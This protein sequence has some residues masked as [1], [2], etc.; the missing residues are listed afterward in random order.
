VPF[1]NGTSV[2]E[3]IDCFRVHDLPFRSR[4]IPQTLHGIKLL[5]RRIPRRVHKPKDENERNHCLCLT[6][7]LD[8][9]RLVHIIHILARS[10][11]LK[12]RSHESADNRED[13]DEHRSR[14]EELGPTTPF[15]R[16][17]GAEDGTGKG[18]DVLHAVVEEAGASVGDAGAPEHGW[19]V[20]GYG[21]VAG[22]LTEEGHR[23]DEHGA[24]AGFAGV[25]EFLGW[26]QSWMM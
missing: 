20:V 6:R 25:E 26:C 5:Q 1:Y 19:V 7:P 15:V 9:R 22:P 17:D 2:D 3:Q 11:L 23:E 8:L 24:V 18:D 16:V 4:F 14:D 13:E 12:I 10:I 21:T